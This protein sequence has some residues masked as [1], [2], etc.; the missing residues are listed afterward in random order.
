MLALCNLGE[1]WAG[2]AP[3]PAAAIAEAHRL[4]LKAVSLDNADAQ[5]HNVLGT[6]L[7]MLGRFDQAV[8]EQ[9]RALELNP[10]LAAAAGELGRLYVFAGRMDD[11]IAYSDRA[12]AASPN[13]PH[14]FV[15]FRNKALARFIVDEYAD[16]AR[17]AADACARS[18]HQFFL[19]YLLAACYAAAEEPERARIAIA[20]GRRL[21]PN[22]TLQMLRIAYPFENR[23]HFEK[24]AEALRQAGWDG[25]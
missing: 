22:Y 9:R 24:Y 25:S 23:A 21:Q 8:A 4:G 13:D 2:V 18:P 14:A 17:H 7:S 10:Y 3:N 15:W 11:A 5:A 1:L 16:A 20:E 19:H 12:I 6:V